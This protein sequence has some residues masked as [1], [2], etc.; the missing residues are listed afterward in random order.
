MLNKLKKRLS[1]NTEIVALALLI[2]TTVLSTTY[3][4]FNKQKIF[5]N[6]K[7][8][9]KFVTFSVLCGLFSILSVI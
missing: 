3:Y 7:L 5:N 1:N 8:A 9:S 6:Y 4:N 2:I